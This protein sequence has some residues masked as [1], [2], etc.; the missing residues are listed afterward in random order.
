MNRWQRMAVW[1]VPL[2]ALLA[3][4]CAAPKID[5]ANIKQ[6]ARAAELDKYNVFVGQWTWEAELL[7]AQGADKQWTG[8]AEWK[9]TLDNR[10]LH[11]T[12]SAKCPDAKFD[13]AGVWSWHPKDKKYIWW[14]FN[15]WGYPQEGTATY[16]ETNKCWSMDY[17][18]VGLDGTSSFGRYTMKVVDPKTLEW[19]MHEWVDF[20]HMT[21]KMEMK[22]T[23]K[24]KS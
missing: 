15:N 10:C 11:G 9:W 4:G 17:K 12:M 14:M 3:S 6:P 21:S 1:A 7:N 23:Y 13:S 19:T 20:T 24:K 22:G 5:F 2:V 18:S 8:T 16:D